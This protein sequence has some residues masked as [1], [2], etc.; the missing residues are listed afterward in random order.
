MAGALDL[1]D[2]ARETTPLACTAVEIRV[3][4][5]GDLIRVDRL[6]PPRSYVLGEEACDFALGS[7]FLGVHRWEAVKV[8]DGTIVVHVPRGMTGTFISPDAEATPIADSCAARDWPLEEGAT[9]HLDLFGGGFSI[10]VLVA[11]REPRTQRAGFDRALLVPFGASLAL[12]LLALAAFF[13]ASALGRAD[14]E[15]E[16][17]DIVF[18][19]RMLQAAQ[20]ESD[21]G[22]IGPKHEGAA[23]DEVV[24][25]GTEPAARDVPAAPRASA[26]APTPD[27][28]AAGAARSPRGGITSSDAGLLANPF[29]PGDEWTGN[30]RCAQGL[31]SLVLRIDG[32]EGNHV[33][34]RFDF[35]YVA[36]GAG[37]SFHM[38]GT[39]N[40]ATRAMT[41]APGEWISKPGPTWFTVGMSGFVD[42]DGREYTGR[43]PVAG[44]GAFSVVK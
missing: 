10:D 5:R 13:P 4:W 36:G 3:T 28:G 1:G 35:N 29:L 17:P 38:A 23:F 42:D 25:A 22:D 21:P 39:F 9:V 14:H 20:G 2:R 32:A 43:I 30:Y 16:K 27:G 12:H 18:L 6:E 44:C 19:R 40:P 37:G 11:R 24:P 34:A 41:F 7:D 26:P 33:R 8:R 31:T 15:V